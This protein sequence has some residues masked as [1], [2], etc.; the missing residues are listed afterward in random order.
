VVEERLVEISENVFYLLFFI[1]TVDKKNTNCITQAEEPQYPTKGPFG[2]ALASPK[3]AL[4]LAHE[5]KP[6]L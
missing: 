1:F 4:A 2:R 3:T 5:V 6:L